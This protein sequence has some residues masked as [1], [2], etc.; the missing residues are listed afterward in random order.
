ME[1]IILLFCLQN[2]TIHSQLLT[3]LCNK[4][5]MRSHKNNSLSLYLSLSKTHSL[6]ETKVKKTP[7]RF[8]QINFF[9]IICGRKGATYL[10]ACKTDILQWLDH[11]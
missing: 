5:Q 11:G 3:L 6:H 9:E 10:R 1:L 2:Y 4:L 8:N 7:D